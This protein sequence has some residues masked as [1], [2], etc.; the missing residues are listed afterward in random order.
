MAFYRECQIWMCSENGS[1]RGRSCRAFLR[2]LNAGMLSDCLSKSAN[3]SILF[4]ILKLLEQVSGRSFRVVQIIRKRRW[5]R[6][7][8][9]RAVLRDAER[10]CGFG[11]AAES[12]ATC[13]ARN[14]RHPT[15][16]NR[17]QRIG[18]EARLSFAAP[19]AGSHCLE[20]H[21]S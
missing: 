12:A 16:D 4:W 10:I 21:L 17:R 3:H 6:V 11:G 5:R 8:R 20:A 15:E 2:S 9:P 1:G 7:R 19:P 13:R 18:P 14:C